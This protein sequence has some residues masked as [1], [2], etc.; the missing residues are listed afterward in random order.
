MTAIN[1]SIPPALNYPTVLNRKGV[2]TMLLFA[3]L[4]PT[5]I[6]VVIGYFVLLTSAKSETPLKTFGRY[7]AIWI[8]ALA[9]VLVIGI[10]TAPMF[11]GRPFGMG[12]MMRGTG[13]HGMM[14]G[15]GM[16]GMMGRPDVMPEP[17]P[18]TQPE[19]VPQSQAEPPKQ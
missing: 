9:A 15:A 5:T 4:I 18:S 1:D 12:G 10:A 13:M 19:P 2:A 7:L 6:L 3:I 11:G 16:R 8:F 14:H 17:P